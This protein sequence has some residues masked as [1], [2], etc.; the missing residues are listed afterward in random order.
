MIAIIQYLE[1]QKLIDE[2]KFFVISKVAILLVLLYSA[3]FWW[4]IPSGRRATIDTQHY[5]L[6]FNIFVWLQI[7]NIFNCRRVNDGMII[8][9]LSFSTL[10]L[11]L[12]VFSIK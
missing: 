3:D 9:L 12:S 7:F 6:I 4:N 11:I 1:T 2:L 10:I 8:F 5:T